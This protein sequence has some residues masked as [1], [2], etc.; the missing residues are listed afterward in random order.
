MKNILRLFCGAGVY[1]FLFFLVLVYSLYAPEGYI[2]IATNKY[3][4]YRKLCLITAAVMIPSVL[5]YYMAPHR[6]GV[7]RVVDNISATDIFVLL[8][9]L[10]NIISFVGTEYR[11]EALWGTSGWYM[12]FGMQLFFI[13]TYFLVSRFYDG[14]IDVL[15]FFM[16]ATFVVFLWGLLNRFSIYPIDMH[17][18]SEQFISS[19]G[20]INWFCGFWSIFF[21]MGVVLYLITTKPSKRANQP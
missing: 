3:L 5:L 20:N 9:L 19:M 17:Y 7:R 14:R 16:T 13:G 10:V 8:Y 11:E 15:P 6:K 1:V 21:V 4:F 18:D 12:G 2:Q